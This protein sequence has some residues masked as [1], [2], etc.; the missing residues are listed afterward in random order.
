[1]KKLLFI[2]GLLVS[3]FASSQENCG[4]PVSLLKS[5]FEAG[6]Q[7]S[8]VTLPPANTP[9]MLAVESPT[10]GSIVGTEFVQVFGNYTG[11]TNT[12]ITVNSI[13]AATTATRYA[14]APIR[15][16][17]GVN[18]ITIVATTTDGV[19]QTV[20]R[21][22]TYDPNQS[23][24]VELA[25]DAF[26]GFAPARVPFAVRYRLPALQTTL[27]RVEIDYQGDG[28]YDFDGPSLPLSLSFNFDNVGD[29]APTVRLTF[30][31]GN[32]VTPL[33]VRNASARVVLESLA[34]TRQTICFVYYE[35]KHRL[36]PGASGIPS[37]L[38]TLVP[39]LRA[40]YQQ[41]WTDLAG[42]LGTAANQVGEIVDGQIADT[43]AEF[44]VAVPDPAVPGEFFGFP[45]HFRRSSDGVWRISEM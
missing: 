33:V 5:G 41:I 24:D 38:N 8:V 37:A 21:T 28:I 1:M 39:P 26:S 35:M 18:T 20:S 45:V 31:D 30:D 2:S 42:N 23:P 11:P 17:V 25:V 12:G 10:Q 22:V 15:L 16:T 4:F 6:E 9:L 34:R 44:T 3:A 43:M 27:T 19:T 13:A 7:P 32:S 29:Y 36:Q 14:S 40:E